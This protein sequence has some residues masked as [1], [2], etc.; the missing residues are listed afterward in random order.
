[1]RS[2]RSRLG[3]SI[4][5]SWAKTFLQPPLISEPMTT[6]PWPFFISQWRMM[7]FCEGMARSRPSRLRPLLMAMQSSPVLKKQ[8][9]IS[10]RSH[11][12]GSHPSPLGPSLLICTPRTVTSVDFRG[13]M[14]QKG[15]SSRV[16]FSISMR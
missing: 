13:C 4:T 5:Q 1:M 8:F 16:T 9:S 12:S 15:E 10:T 3:E 2:T 11:D 6:P 7:M 14:T